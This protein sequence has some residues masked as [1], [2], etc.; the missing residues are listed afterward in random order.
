[1][2]RFIYLSLLSLGLFHFSGHPSEAEEPD[3]AH[4]LERGFPFCEITVDGRK[5]G[6]GFPKDNLTPRGLVVR[7]A[8]ETY[9]AY[10]TD[11]CRVALA[12]TGGFLTEESL[13]LKSYREPKAKKNGGQKSLPSPIGQPLFA[14]GLYAGVQRGREARLRDPRPPGKNPRE[15]GRGALAEGMAR[16]VSSTV[17]G[18]RVKVSYEIGG[19]MIQEIPAALSGDEE[20]ASREPAIVRYFRVSAHPEV[21]LTIVLGTQHCQVVGAPVG[22]QLQKRRGIHSLSI[23]PSDAV[24]EF[25]VVQS[26][27]KFEGALPAHTAPKEWEQSPP[28]GHWPKK[29]MTSGKLAPD[30]AAYVIDEIPLPLA[31][32]AGRNVRPIDLAFAETYAVM[33]TFDGDL[34]KV[35]GLEGDLKKIEWQRIASGLHEPCSVRVRG[36][37]IFVFSRNGITKV[38]SDGAALVYENY[39]SDF[40][41]S[42]DS[43]D[44]AHSFDFDDEGNIYLSKGG[45]QNDFPSKHS[46][47]V[48]KIDQER[49]VSVFASGL[50]NP[51]L[52]VRPGTAEIYAS[53]Q[54]G[55]W[56]PATPVHRIT[57]GAY[58]GFRPSAP[59]GLPEP[60]LTPP[61][62]WIPHTVASSGLGVIWADDERFGPLSDSL[63]YLDYTGPQIMRTYLHEREGQAATLPLPLTP[64]F[65]L[66]KGAVNPAD[67]QLYLVGFQIWG[68]RAGAIRGMGRLRFTGRASQLPSRVLA[69][70]NALSLRFD[71]PLDP[72]FASL[73]ARR[74]NYQR[75]GIYGS[76]HYRPDG[77][78]GEE[79]LPL[80]RVEFSKDRRAILV[81]TPELQR[82]DQLAFTYEL[83][84]AAGKKFTHSVY[85]TLHEVTPLDLAQEGFPEVD[86]AKLAATADQPEAQNKSSV[87][88]PTIERG[89]HVYKTIGCIA[90]HSVDGTSNGRSG[91]TWKNLAGSQRELLD[92]KRVEVDAAY[93]RESILDP[94]AKVAK[95]YHPKDVGMPSYRG[96][97]P[98]SDIDS[99]VLYIQS[100]AE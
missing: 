20:G 31:H 97:L 44:F 81:A 55:H 57:P 60:P 56:V 70:K 22:S 93:L 36:H 25:A 9:L 3:D 21:A 42:A 12:W 47:R 80:S 39:S 67:G 99:L 16:W 7:L 91:P 87:V 23:E 49:K 29:I 53:D 24:Q 98:D 90:C 58:Y 11:L 88:Q 69:G 48:L 85:F 54:Q 37:E 35:R 43:R 17:L 79:L 82:V 50:R 41:Q 27:H 26:L 13:A 46:G 32:P 65:P 78:A 33:V 15:I 92:G 38:R 77:K 61:L 66:L 10:D 84:T 89:V 59:W 83:K 74:W 63:I 40:W 1:M 45:Q 52:S 75:S 62:C 73:T 28:G 18:E 19:V 4:F 72:S 14:N 8:E 68:S 2:I 51:Y 6:E 34:W 100:L 30:E 94:A 71:E 5:L 86:L 95:G 96:I 76:G 64:T